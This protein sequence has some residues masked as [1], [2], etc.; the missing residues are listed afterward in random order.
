MKKIIG[1]QLIFL[2]LFFGLFLAPQA[3]NASVGVTFSVSSPTA[4]TVYYPGETMCM[5]GTITTTT[6]G[7][8]VISDVSYTLNLAGQQFSG[9]LNY[10]KNA[11]TTWNKC[12]IVPPTTP[13]GPTNMNLVLSVV[14]YHGGSADTINNA[15]NSTDTSTYNVP[16]IIGQ[17][18]VCG[19]AVNTPTATRPSS[20]LCNTGN[21]SNV[22]RKESD[23]TW[24]WS[25]DTNYNYPSNADASC[26]PSN[27]PCKVANT[28]IVGAC[29]TNGASY[30]PG[31]TYP[32]GATSFTGT[33]C[34]NNLTPTPSR[35]VFPTTSTPTTWTCPN[36]ASYVTCGAIFTPGVCN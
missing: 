15:N 6:C 2:F 26:V 16:V 17:K 36:G 25:C 1:I 29:G 9:H 5:N 10:L 27:T 34:I 14:S 33:F 35:P 19:S 12:V 7:N 4:N 23:G 18:G 22:S 21:P 32:A 11:T 20:G 3:V 8:T 24:D 13:C 31:K 28:G 30:P